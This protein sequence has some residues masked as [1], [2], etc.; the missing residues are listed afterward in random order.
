MFDPLCL[1]R[2][3]RD[4]NP[5]AETNHD[6]VCTSIVTCI[7]CNRSSSHPVG[8]LPICSHELA[9][10]DFH[11]FCPTLHKGKSNPQPMRL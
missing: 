1:A 3:K 7:R 8:A 10:M 4:F 9:F 2:M 5:A 6:T 11:E